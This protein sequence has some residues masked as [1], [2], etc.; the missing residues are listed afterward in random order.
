[1]VGAVLAGSAVTSSAATPRTYVSKCDHTAIKPAQIL[2]ACGDGGFY[3]DH[4]RWGF[5]GKYRAHGRGIFHQN[6]CMPDCARGHFHARRGHITLRGRR[7][8]SGVKQWV[9]RRAL[10]HFRRPL[11]GR[12]E[13]DFAMPCPF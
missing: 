11:L 9:F 1:M 10:I 2:F 12:S 5:W 6:D 3:A 13:V 8:C 7:W 4:L